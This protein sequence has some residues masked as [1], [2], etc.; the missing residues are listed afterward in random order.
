MN[1]VFL[2]I[3]VSFLCFSRPSVAQN[4]TTAAPTPEEETCNF[5]CKVKNWF[6]EAFKTVGRKFA[7]WFSLFGDKLLEL[8]TD[9]QTAFQA[10]FKKARD[11]TVDFFSTAVNDDKSRYGQ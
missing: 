4:V 8:L 7:E 9:I 3:G 2:F 10:A 1:L 6:T 11:E 5:G